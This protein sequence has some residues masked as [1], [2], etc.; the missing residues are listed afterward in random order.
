[1]I[2]SGYFGSLLLQFT[3]CLHCSQSNQTDCLRSNKRN[4][5]SMRMESNDNTRASLMFD[6]D[7]L[8]MCPVPYHSYALCMARL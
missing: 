6:P 8:K 7:L 3:L 4:S 1:M 2:E 5:F